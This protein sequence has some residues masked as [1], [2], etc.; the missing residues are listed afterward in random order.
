MLV[1]LDPIQ[2]KVKI[3]CQQTQ[4]M[5][6]HPED[7]IMNGI[8]LENTNL[9]QSNQLRKAYIINKLIILFIVS[10]TKILHKILS[11]IVMG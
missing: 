6:K 11:S 10:Q 7:K 2:L 5:S 3:I 1:Q 4:N 9:P 8:F